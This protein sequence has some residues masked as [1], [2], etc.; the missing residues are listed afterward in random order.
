MRHLVTLRDGIL[1]EAPG[2]LHALGLQPARLRGQQPLVRLGRGRRRLPHQLLRVPQLALELLVGEAL[3]SDRVPARKL[4][5]TLAI[6]GL[7]ATP[8]SML[9]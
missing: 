2:A 4:G 6:R 9:L 5:E 7:L 1:L 8:A 3:G